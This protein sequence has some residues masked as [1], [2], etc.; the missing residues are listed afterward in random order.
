MQKFPFPPIQ[1]LW[2]YMK[3][4]NGLLAESH[5]EQIAENTN[6][7]LKRLDSVLKRGN[8]HIVMPRRFAFKK[9]DRVLP[10][11]KLKQQQ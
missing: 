7:L 11:N 4:I 8:L 6:L 10:K 2:G 5:K 9:I 3:V 1:S